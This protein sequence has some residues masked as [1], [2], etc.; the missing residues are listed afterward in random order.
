MDAIISKDILLKFDWIGYCTLLSTSIKCTS[1]WV[2]VLLINL[3][4]MICT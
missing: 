4:A 1:P 3:I 2:G